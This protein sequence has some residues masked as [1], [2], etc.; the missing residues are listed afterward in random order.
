M[1]VTVGSTIDPLESRL[2]EQV[3]SWDLLSRHRSFRNTNTFR[4]FL[5]DHK[6]ATILCALL[7]ISLAIILGVLMAMVPAW[8]ASEAED[9]RNGGKSGLA[10]GSGSGFSLGEPPYNLQDLCSKESRYAPGG[11][12][13]CVSA[14]LPSR[15]CLVPEGELHELWKPD[16]GGSGS[17]SSASLRTAES[18]ETETVSSCYS[19]NRDTCNAYHKQCSVLGV[20][21]LLPRKPPSTE[22]VTLMGEGEKLDLAEWILHSCSDLRRTRSTSLVTEDV[23]SECQMLC[24]EKECCFAEDSIDEKEK[25]IDNAMSTF[26]AYDE[27]ASPPSDDS[28]H[29]EEEGPF[30]EKIPTGS[31]TSGQSGMMG[32]TELPT[33]GISSYK[34]TTS[35][36]LIYHTRKRRGLEVDDSKLSHMEIP[37]EEDFVYD[38]AEKNAVATDPYA[39]EPVPN[40]SSSS[41]SSSGS[42][43]SNVVTVQYAN[44]EGSAPSSLLP[45]KNCVN[46]PR[47]YCAIYAGC[48]PLFGT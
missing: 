34:P 20:H 42:I 39:I 24:Q 27:V 7:S 17:I 40:S 21:A 25:L 8:M 11:H 3:S 33:Q 36:T 31:P 15:C 46:D 45:K 28:D 32:V 37:G 23:S 48:A 14:C 30:Y 10:Y 29:E 18:E 1:T 26:S 35:G 12:D 2:G 41:S 13:N 16:V 43:G 22:E 9:L 6:K 19:Q 5:Q 4:S 44:S 47:Q 38:T